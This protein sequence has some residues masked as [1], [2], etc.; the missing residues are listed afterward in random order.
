LPADES[1]PDA[2]GVSVNGQH[3]AFGIPVDDS[4]E[5]VD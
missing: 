5:A 2:N 4:L 1:G 3:F